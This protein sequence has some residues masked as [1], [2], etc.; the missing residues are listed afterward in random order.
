MAIPII[1]TATTIMTTV[2]KLITTINLINILNDNT[3]LGAT[4]NIINTLS[5]SLSL[6]MFK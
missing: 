2:I 6:F 3:V 5:L 4:S 1:N